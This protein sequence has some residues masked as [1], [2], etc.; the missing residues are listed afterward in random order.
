[1]Q[2]CIGMD[3]RSSDTT[4]NQRH[5]TADLPGIGGRLKAE[6]ED[7]LVEETPAFEPTGEGEHLYLWVE[8]RNIAHEQ[9]VR[10]VAKALGIS[11]GDVGTAGMKDRVAV[12]RQWVSVPAKPQAVVDRLSEI[13]GVRILKTSRHPHKLR[14]GKLRGNRFEILVR[15]VVDNSLETAEAIAER[16]R[17]HG[18]PNYFGTQRF[19]RDDETLRTGFQLLCGEKTPKDLPASRRRFLLRLSLSAVQSFLFNEALAERLRDGL[20]STVLPGDVMRVTQSGGIFLAEDPAAEQPRL[21]AGEIAVT[22][23]MFGPKMRQ[24]AGEVQGRETKLLE[25]HGL[26]M[27]A[28]SQFRKLTPG[29]RRAYG[30]IPDDL[31]IEPDTDGL[32]FHFTLPSGS[33]ATVLLDEFMK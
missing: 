8:K 21:D 2:T 13:D 26:T 3:R 16:I 30:V 11:R 19:G 22:G 5:L 7:F 29:T 6:P 15:D 20:F 17:R 33:Y 25:L 18:F 14:T 24:P 27:S 23:P 9:L 1:M 10:D 31:R 4:R 32:R 28:W 12:T